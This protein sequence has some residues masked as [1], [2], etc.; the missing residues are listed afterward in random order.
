MLGRYI[1][2]SV[3]RVEGKFLSRGFAGGEDV[4]VLCGTSFND[5]DQLHVPSHSSPENDRQLETADSGKFS[6]C[7][8][9]TA[10]DHALVEDARL[11]GYARL[12]LQSGDWSRRATRASFVSAAAH[13]QKG[14]RRFEF[15]PSRTAVNARC[16]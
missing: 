6:F 7:A 1:R 12:F 4:A 13:V 10:K 8:E 11:R 5:G 16:V 3:H 14:R 15:V 9:S 2:F